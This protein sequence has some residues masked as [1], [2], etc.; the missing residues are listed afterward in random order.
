MTRHL[1]HAMGCEVAVPPRL[2]MCRRHWQ[3]VPRNLQA[4]V[5]DAYVPGQELRKDP[6]AEYL[7]AA[8]AA[9]EAVA[10]REAAP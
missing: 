1:C 5:Y 9:I 10:G 2:L 3:M 7:E 8:M 4:A 6:T